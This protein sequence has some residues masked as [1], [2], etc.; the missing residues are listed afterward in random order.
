M[1]IGDCR[2]TVYEPQRGIVALADGAGQAVAVRFDGMPL[3]AN[4]SQSEALFAIRF[5]V[6]C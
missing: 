4:Y 6:R 5:L 3:M 2:L 1:G